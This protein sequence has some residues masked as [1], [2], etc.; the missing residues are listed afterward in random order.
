MPENFPHL[1]SGI[2]PQIQETQIKHQAGEM[3]K[4]Y[5]PSYIN[6]KLQIMVVK[7]KHCERSQRK[8]P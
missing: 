4:K 1:M 5:I 7:E 8:E 2:K 3:P 6:F